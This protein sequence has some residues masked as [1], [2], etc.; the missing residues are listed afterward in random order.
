MSGFPGNVLRFVL[1][2]DIHF[3]FFDSAF[4]PFHISLSLRTADTESGVCR[5][6]SLR[7]S[8]GSA[9]IQCVSLC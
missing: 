9:Y 1:Y 6:F 2:V 8:F 4:F 7:L 3:L 5:N